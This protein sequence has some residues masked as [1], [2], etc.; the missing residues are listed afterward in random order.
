MMGNTS[1]SLV[2]NAA[3]SFESQRGFR[4]MHETS[5]D[6]FDMTHHV[7]VRGVFLGCKYGVEQMLKQS[8]KFGPDRGWSECHYH[9]KPFH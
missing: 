5:L 8:P 7:N 3:I 6:E 1:N 9:P 2:N 4:P